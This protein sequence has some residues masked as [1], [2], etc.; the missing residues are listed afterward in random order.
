[1]TLYSSRVRE[2]VQ[3]FRL[4]QNCIFFILGIIV[5][6]FNAVYHF[7]PKIRCVLSIK[8]IL[9]KDLLLMTKSFAQQSF[10]SVLEKK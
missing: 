10:I 1:M 3:L 9:T 7:E 5:L 4:T 2:N 6:F 8:P